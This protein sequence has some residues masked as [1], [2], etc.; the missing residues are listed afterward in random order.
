MQWSTKDLV[1]LSFTRLCS[2]ERALSEPRRTVPR[3]LSARTVDACCHLRPL[4]FKSRLLSG[5]LASVMDTG[6]L[7]SPC[8]R[9]A[10]G[11]L[12]DAKNDVY[13]SPP[14]KRDKVAGPKRN[15]PRESRAA[16]LRSE[17]LT[18]DRLQLTPGLFLVHLHHL[19][20]LGGNAEIPTLA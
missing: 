17:P 18:I 12:H 15:R 13:C 6:Y 7:V 10:T 9:R 20:L 19:F 2:E 14:L 4:K 5:Q 16:S 1:M 3:H 11:G 8:K